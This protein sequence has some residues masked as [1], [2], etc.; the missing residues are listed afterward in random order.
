M[1]SEYRERWKQVV[2]DCAGALRKPTDLLNRPIG[3]EDFVDAAIIGGFSLSDILEGKV[4]EWQIPS[5]VLEA[6]HAQ[7]PQ[8]G[9]SFVEAVNRFDGHPEQLMGLVNG[10]K[11]KLFENDYADWL[12][13]G[14]L[15]AG[16]VAEL[17]QGANNP[18]WD[19]SIHDSHGHVSELL[20]LKA[21]ESLSYVRAAIDAHPEIDVVVPH[22]LYTKV[23]DADLLSHL[24]D[25]HESLVHLNDHVS[26]AVGHAESAGAAEHFPVIGPA[27][28]IS[29]VAAANWKQYRSG[30]LS[31]E[32][33][34]RN[35][36]ERGSLSILASA[37]GWA[38]GALAHEPTLGLPTAVTVRLVGGSS[39]TTADVEN[40]WN[41]ASPSCS[42]LGSAS[43]SICNVRCS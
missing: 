23:V 14:H 29:M 7:Y 2:T 40:C 6:F 24:T 43:R 15:P 30:K 12:N 42:N 34:L 22:D 19:I 5:N 25:G 33:A 26:D 41:S 16:F 1:R 3:P 11:G 35:I 31:R 9:A 28:V 13:H 32:E 21:T 36:A 37:S 18:G 39:F 27:L 4:A 20:Q 10:I 17:A 38:L 8:Y